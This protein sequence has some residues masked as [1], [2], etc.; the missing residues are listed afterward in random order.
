MSSR[1]LVKLHTIDPLHDRRW[2]DLVARHPRSSAFHQ[3]GWIESLKLTYGYE[4]FVLTST[5][6]G[7]PL[8]NGLLLCLVASWITGTRAV[9]LPFADHCEPLL[10]LANEEHPFADWLW[11][12]CD[13]QRWKYVELRPLS[14]HEKSCNQLSRSQ[15][16]CLHTLDLTGSSEEVF[17]GFHKNSIQRRISRAEGEGLD[18]ETGCSGQLLDEFYGL[19]LKTRRRHQLPPQPRAWF[20][21]LA[22]RL[23]DK[24]EIRVARQGHIPIAALLSLRH[25]TSVIYKYGCSDET[26][27]RFGAVP[28]L[29]WK[30]IQESKALGAEEFDFGRSDLEQQGL[31]I[32][33]ERF[34]AKRRTLTYF[35][36]PMSKPSNTYLDWSA[37][38]GRKVISLLPDA[39]LPLAGRI[40]YKHVG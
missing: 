21:N 26:F 18:Y 39:V 17:H 30:L 32:F 20:R 15:S 37:R 23:G 3:R 27:H 34:G 10:N 7:K 33:K 16:Y 9:S 12:E 40:L 38:A 24:L 19:M 11:K 1:N 6:E 35:R 13:H 31:I 28:F 29:F 5:P 36:Y 25:R 14:W 8:E 4:P 22:A 2:D